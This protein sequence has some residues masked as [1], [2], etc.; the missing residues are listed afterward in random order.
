VQGVFAQTHPS[1]MK[2]SK[3]RTQVTFLAFFS[4]VRHGNYLIRIFY[5]E[6]NAKNLQMNLTIILDSSVERDVSGYLAV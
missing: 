5:K 1:S 3:N 2:C 4:S 6:N